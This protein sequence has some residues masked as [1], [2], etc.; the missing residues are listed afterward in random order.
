M[1]HHLDSVPPDIPNPGDSGS[2]SGVGDL[3][4]TKEGSSP[5]TYL[6]RGHSGMPVTPGSLRYLGKTH[7]GQ[8]GSLRWS[9]RFRYTWLV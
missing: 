7:S 5:G 9:H 3:F 8:L 1:R 4:G 6:D 2:L